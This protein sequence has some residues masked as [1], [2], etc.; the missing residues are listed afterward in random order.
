[1]NVI[2]MSDLLRDINQLEKEVMTIA[3]ADHEKYEYFFNKILEVKQ[4]LFD[5]EDD[6]NKIELMFSNDKETLSGKENRKRYRINLYKSILEDLKKFFNIDLERL[7]K[8]RTKWEEEK[9]GNWGYSPVEIDVIEDV[10]A[11]V[12][13]G[14]Q[15]KSLQKNSTML[16]ENFR[17]FCEQG[18]YEKKIK[19]KLLE[20][21]QN[22]ELGTTKRLDLEQLFTSGNV[23]DI[24]NSKA[25]WSAVSGIEVKEEA[26]MNFN[27]PPERVE[28][29]P[30]SILQ[31]TTA[32]VPSSNHSRKK[33]LV[34]IQ[35][36]IFGKTIQIQKKFKLYKGGRFAIP[37]FLE[38]KVFAIAFPEGMTQIEQVGLW[39]LKNLEQVYLPESLEEI[40]KEAFKDCGNLKEV[41]IP[42]KV[43][44]IGESAFYYCFSLEKVNLKKS[45]VSE[46]EGNA[47]KFCEKLQEV[48]LPNT[49]EKIGSRAFYASGVRKINF[50][51]SLK[52]IGHLAFGETEIEQVELP[53]HVEKLG[54]CV[55]QNCN[56][57]EKVKLS[58]DIK[59][60]PRAAFMDCQN[61]RNI[62]LPKRL[63][64]I[65]GEAFCRCCS[66]KKIHLPENV[67]EV[68]ELAFDDCFDLQ[69]V[70]IENE[71]IEMGNNA[72]PF[73]I[74]FKKVSNQQE[75]GDDDQKRADDSRR[76]WA[77][78]G[79][80]YNAKSEN[81]WVL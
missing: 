53:N 54:E 62:S 5:V 75:D 63:V 24:V 52:S 70:E 19:E 73:G 46:I 74:Q 26:K 47:F 65:G 36:H 4:E 64:K 77:S 67:R 50:P 59:E 43:K 39:R 68:E 10:F 6:H 27:P 69:E 71:N 33:I 79:K 40:G 1:M 38:D 80:K 58:D 29:K 76:N 57:L 23:G 17:E 78:Q 31:E 15:I 37:D 7:R 81:D 2:G 41:T 30:I 51:E 20:K 45:Q 12:F 49:V 11:E 32:I 48:D 9:D 3:L 44:R 72:F 16:K 28:N 34:N 25:F 66:L 8:L 60:I 56:K 42:Q 21:I 35:F 55:F 13:L 18:K 61:L 14:Y 22:L